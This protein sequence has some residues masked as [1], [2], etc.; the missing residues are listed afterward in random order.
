M[1]LVPLLAPL[2]ISSLYAQPEPVQVSSLTA[3]APVAITGAITCSEKIGISEPKDTASGT[4]D[5][6]NTSERGIVALEAMVAVRCRH[7]SESIRYHFDDLFFTANGLSP[8]ASIRKAI[9]ELEGSMAS[10]SPLV[11]SPR[12]KVKIQLVEFADGSVWGDSTVM[13]AVRV[14]R[15]NRESQLGR[16]ASASNDGEFD[17]ILNKMLAKPEDNFVYSMAYKISMVRKKS[18]QAALADVRD[19]LRVAENR[20]ASGKF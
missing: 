4:L 9:P 20:E 19:R 12:V 17:S 13:N 7:D 6:A 11:E 14:R 1:K 2:M 10:Y 15:K 18:A 8:R 3:D 5:F 16:L